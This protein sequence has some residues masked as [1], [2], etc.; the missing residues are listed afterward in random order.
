MT[1]DEIT[2]QATVSSKIISTTFVNGDYLVREN[3]GTYTLK[4]VNGDIFEYTPSIS[5]QLNDSWSFA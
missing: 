4:S 3:S 1:W 2:S 5:E